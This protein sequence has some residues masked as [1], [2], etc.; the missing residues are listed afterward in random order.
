MTD[1]HPDTSANAV[2]CSLRVEGLYPHQFLTH[3]APDGEMRRHFGDN[4]CEEL[5]EAGTCLWCGGSHRQQYGER[6][7]SQMAC[8][9][10]LRGVI[11]DLA[12]THDMSTSPE[13][14]EL[15]AHG[16]SA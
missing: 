4:H 9:N 15:L 11:A 1:A 2:L 14:Y 13:V 16:G 6:G 10:Y 8:I 7:A 3:Q 5:R 12:N